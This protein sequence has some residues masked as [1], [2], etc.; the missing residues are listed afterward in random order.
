MKCPICRKEVEPGS[1]YAPF[2]SDRCRLIDLG[3][4]ATGKYRI[5]T[6]APPEEAEEPVDED[7]DRED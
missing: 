6:P 3:N 4:W 5:S 7:D 1:R 2:C